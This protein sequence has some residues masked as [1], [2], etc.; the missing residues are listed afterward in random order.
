[1]L[2]FVVIITLLG[3]AIHILLPQIGEIGQAFQTLRTG[4]W[5]YLGLTLV[6]SALTY[7]TGAWMVSA[8][9][10]LRL[11]FIRTVLSQV[12]ATL[13]ATMTPA[14]LGWVATTDDY[15]QKAGADEHTAHAATTL[16]M[17]ITFLSHL[18]LLAILIPFLPTLDLTHHPPQPSDHP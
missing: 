6:G 15:L 1:M 13:M 7:V 3:F 11:P 9:T 4:S 18:A 2:R 16:N 10:R 12:A 8:S 5:R 14:G 17:V